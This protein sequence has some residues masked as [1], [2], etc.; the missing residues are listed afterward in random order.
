V[1]GA[2]RARDQSGEIGVAGWRDAMKMELTVRRFGEHERSS[3]DGS[4]DT[5]TSATMS[6]R[7]E[8]NPGYTPRPF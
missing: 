4:T 7:I 2:R 3:E 1:R 5:P 6:S 8:A